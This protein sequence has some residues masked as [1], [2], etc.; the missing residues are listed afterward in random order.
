MTNVEYTVVF[1]GHPKNIPGNPFDF[2]SPFGTVNALAASNCM[3]DA[4]RFREALEE[5]AD[6]ASY[7]AAAIA[8]AALAERD[9]ALKRN[10]L[11]AAGR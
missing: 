7:S 10:L 5:I 4:D 2:Q 11:A 1:S 9:A 3:E 8:R 6:G